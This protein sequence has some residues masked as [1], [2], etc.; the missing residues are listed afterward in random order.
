MPSEGLVAYFSQHWPEMLA[1]GALIP[2][3][4]F[5]TNQIWQL[6]RHTRLA[7]IR[8]EI[9]ET[10]EFLSRYNGES[11]LDA[12]AAQALHIYRE[13]RQKMFEEV[14]RLATPF[15][16]SHPGAARLFSF[17]LVSRPKYAISLLTRVIFFVGLYVFCR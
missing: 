9:V 4:Q 14:Q 7:T 1:S 5:L 12:A 6:R 15:H 11:S 3:L 2:G 13:E 8:K 16:V 10:D 17:F